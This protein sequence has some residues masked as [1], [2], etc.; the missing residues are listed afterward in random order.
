MEKVNIYNKFQKIKD[1]WN[2]RIVGELN[3]QHLKLVKVQGKF[4][5]HKHDYE[6]EMFI[7]WKGI[8]QVELPDKTVEMNEGEFIIIP[9][10]TRHRTIAHTE[11]HLLLFE[12]AGTINTGDER[13]DMTIKAP[14]KI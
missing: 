3:G 4:L 9:A 10:G 11:A 12:P 13:T 14:E 1:Y 7:V 2:P 8:L 6:D 5:W